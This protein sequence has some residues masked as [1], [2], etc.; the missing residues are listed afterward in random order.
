MTHLF[1]L[2]RLSPLQ[3]KEYQCKYPQT[4]GEQ[5]RIK[6]R[7]DFVPVS[8]IFRPTVIFELSNTLLEPVPSSQNTLIFVR[9]NMLSGIYEN[10]GQDEVRSSKS[11][12]EVDFGK[13]SRHFFRGIVTRERQYV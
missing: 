11:F 13:V 8:I 7:D 10:Y 9:Q 12:K 1:K 2:Y 3:S 5:E 4:R 6:S